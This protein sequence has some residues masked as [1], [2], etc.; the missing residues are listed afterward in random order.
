MEWLRKICL[1]VFLEVVDEENERGK[2]PRAILVKG[3]ADVA[4]HCER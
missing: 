4:S 3:F 2:W 1:R